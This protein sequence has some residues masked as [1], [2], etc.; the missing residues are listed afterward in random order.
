MNLSRVRCLY[1]LFSKKVL[2]GRTDGECIPF[3]PSKTLPCD[4]PNLRF[5]PRKAPEK[6]GISSSRVAE[7]LHALEGGDRVP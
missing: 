1:S 3:T 5:F 6:Y 4:A 7:L 2:K